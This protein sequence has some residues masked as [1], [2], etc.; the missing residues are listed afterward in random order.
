MARRRARG[1]GNISMNMDSMMDALTNVVAVLILVLVVV[2]LN[3]KQKIAQYIQN[4][5]SIT[6]EE[7]AKNQNKVLSLERQLAQQR[8]LQNADPLS[9]DAL[10]SEQQQVIALQQQLNKK[11]KENQ[12]ISKLFEQEKSL[13]AFE[14]REKKTLERLKKQLANSNLK[15]QKTPEKKQ[16]TKQ[17][18]I[19]VSREI[20]DN[21]QVYYAIVN[22]KRVFLLDPV[23]PMNLFKQE[24]FRNG[25]SWILEKG[26][27]NDGKKYVYYDRSKIV[28]H[29]KN[30][31]FR[32]REGQSIRLHTTPYQWSYSLEYKI[33]N[34]APH[35]KLS[36]L[37]KTDNAFAKIMSRVSRNRSAVLMF[38]VHG[39]DFETYVAA[40]AIVDK[41]RIPAGWQIKWGLVHYLTIP[42]FVSKPTKKREP[43]KN[44][45]PPKR[46]PPNRGLK[47]E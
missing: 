47:L 1:G 30:F 27:R 2:Q 5:E 12:K 28:A 14:Q 45:T 4:L 43:S 10:K 13:L 39:N 7:L 37:K 32:P 38:L 26:K 36:E 20:P 31:D 6:V 33:S 8:A 15:L 40:R 41:Y 42:N 23:A 46:R 44:P 29:F 21:A 24:V 3:V 18:G 16:N 19:P 9:P 17:L 35:Y 34:N 25:P 11:K 22:S